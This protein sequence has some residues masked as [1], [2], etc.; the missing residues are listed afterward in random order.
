MK[1]IFFF[2]YFEKKY[3]FCC[4]KYQSVGNRQ[5]TVL[6][7]RYEKENPLTLSGATDWQGLGAGRLAAPYGKSGFG[8]SPSV[9]GCEVFNVTQ[10][11]IRALSFIGRVFIFIT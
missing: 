10:W 6:T 8:V 2:G 1:K 11:N 7:V 4:W 5:D 3:Y 9:L